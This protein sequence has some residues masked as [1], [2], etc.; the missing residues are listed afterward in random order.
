MLK[1]TPKSEAIVL[2]DTSFM[3]QSKI[4]AIIAD[5]KAGRTDWCECPNGNRD[6]MTNCRCYDK[7]DGLYCS[8]CNGLLL[9]G[10]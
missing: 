1:A 3:D 5:Y 6:D 8:D 4:D 10:D 7:S 9:L 2:M